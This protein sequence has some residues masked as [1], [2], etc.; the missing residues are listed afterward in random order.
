M[1]HAPAAGL[2]LLLACGSTALSSDITTT[3]GTVYRDARVTTVDPDG[4]HI[5]HKF[6]VAK[7]PF[8]ELSEGVRAKYH[9]DKR[10]ADAYRQQ[11]RARQRSIATKSGTTQPQTQAAQPT[12]TQPPG[13]SMWRRQP[14]PGNDFPKRKSGIIAIIVSYG[15]FFVT[16]GLAI[17]LYFLPTIVGLRKQ[18][19]GGIFLLNLVLGWTLAG[20]IGALIWACTAESRLV[21]SRSASH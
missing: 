1:R 8:E 16:L 13:Q 10:K 6:G 12:G 5:V 3:N 17:V 14:G 21:Q 9:Y 15:V 4:L 19:A 2:L 18:N 11:I 7:V 20:W